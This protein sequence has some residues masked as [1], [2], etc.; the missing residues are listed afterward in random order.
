[1]TRRTVAVLAITMLCMF[2]MY[3]IAFGFNAADL[4]A[5]KAT[6][7]CSRCDLSGANLQGVN[8]KGANLS[9]TN[10]TRA[11]LDGANLTGANLYE[12]VLSG[13]NL[14][15]ARLSGSIWT[16]GITCTQGS[17]GQCKH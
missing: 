16:D 11:N 10:L 9:W 17:V 4:A 1:M 14:T 13:V 15:G 2:L 6:H 8:L 3:S 7:N 12:A 5:L